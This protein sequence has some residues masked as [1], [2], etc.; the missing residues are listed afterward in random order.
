MRYCLRMVV[1]NT[2]LLLPY[3]PLGVCQNRYGM[4]KHMMFRK[5]SLSE[6][7]RFADEVISELDAIPG[8]VPE[9]QPLVDRVKANF[10]AVKQAS[11]GLSHPE[12]AKAKR[13]G[14]A[15]RDLGLNTLKYNAKRSLK[16]RDERWVAAGKFI[17]R[18]IHNFGDGMAR[19]SL[20]SETTSVG[21][22]LAEIDRN[23]EL[24]AAI[25]TI[26]CDA[27]L[28]DIRD[29]QREVEE[30]SAARLAIL[31]DKPKVAAYKEAVP[32]GKNLEK[33][34]RLI[35]MKLEFEDSSEF[36]AL[37]HRINEIVGRYRA[38]IKHRQTL[39]K[40]A[41]E[42]KGNGNEQEQNDKK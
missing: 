21:N 1:Q 25:S 9:L 14:D 42:K 2:G 38:T 17:L 4:I 7:H 5:L 39:R 16:R 34:F 8:N 32:L 6:K 37:S 23:A 18:V 19:E 27:W 29:G 15:L 13:A 10:E 22:L 33:L 3:A 26:G 24:R 36:V 40:Q 41:K 11:L 30:A 28:Q 20:I 12:F 31:S 35:N